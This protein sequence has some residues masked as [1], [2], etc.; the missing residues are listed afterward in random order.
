[1]KISFDRTQMAAAFSIAASVVAP[2]S[3]K[4]VL[5]NVKMEATPDGVVLTGTDTEIGVRVEVGAVTVE[6]PGTVLL[7][8]QRF[9]NLIRENSDER[10]QLSSD[11]NGTTV[12]GQRATLKFPS[13]NPDEFPNLPVSREDRC[14][15]VSTRLFHELARRTL[16]A[17][18][19]ESSRYALAGVLLE[20]GEDRITA[21]GTD[22]RRLA[23]MEGLATSI[24]DHGKEGSTTI[25]PARALQLMDRGL[26]D[27][28][29]DLQITTRVNDIVVRKNGITFFSR[30]LEGKFPRWRD[31]FPHRNQASRIPLS[32]GPF[33]TALRQAA[34]VSSDE[35]RGIDFTFGEGTLSM[36]GSTAE[37]GQSLVDLPIEYTGPK[38]T[39]A[40]DNRYVSDVLKVLDSDRTVTVELQSSEG[41]VLFLTDDGY[42]YVVMP[43]SKDR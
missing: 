12:K 34:I 1:M 7:P 39:V 5:Q 43:L 18:E 10:L 9:G 14:H 27:G 4:P 28:E 42:A 16:F 37:V 13:V 41:A 36:S 20:F 31:V 22:G 40:L 35:S 23:K 32:V 30:L 17:T 26:S 3:P 38:I 29:G 25:V 19:S 24:G 6:Q 21:V 2:R 8:V 33:F 15:I 11:S